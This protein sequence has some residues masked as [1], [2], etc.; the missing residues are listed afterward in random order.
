MADVSAAT[1][2]TAPGFS[3]ARLSALGAGVWVYRHEGGKPEVSPDLFWERGKAFFGMKDGDC[4]IFIADR[5]AGFV[6]V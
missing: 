3:P 4:V 5:E 2:Q 6:V 1:K